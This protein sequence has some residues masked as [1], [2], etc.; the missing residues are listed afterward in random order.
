MASVALF[1]TPSYAQQKTPETSLD[2]VLGAK[3]LKAAKA[4]TSLTVDEKLNVYR[5][6]MVKRYLG[7]EE[8]ALGQAIKYSCTAPVV[9]VVFYIGDDLGKHSPE[10]IVNHIETVFSQHGMQAKVFINHQQSY[11]SSVA[12]I[13]DGGKEV[14][15]PVPPVQAIKQ[16]KSF[17]ADMKLVFFADKLITSNELAKWAKA[18]TPYIPELTRTK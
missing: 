5:C 17:S 12:Y 15:D 10:K 16:I 18:T 14:F 9:G 13:V 3:L 11:S 7:F 2:I 6:E 1:L 8:T 4:N